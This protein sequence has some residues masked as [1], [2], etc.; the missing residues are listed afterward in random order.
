METRQDGPGREQLDAR[1]GQLDRQRQAIQADAQLG[2]RF[3]MED[4]AFTLLR[5]LRNNSKT[6]AIPVFALVVKT[7]VQQQQQAQ[8]VGFNAVGRPSVPAQ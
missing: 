4:F 6:K 8:S 5:Q 2:D 1:G 7:D 3:S